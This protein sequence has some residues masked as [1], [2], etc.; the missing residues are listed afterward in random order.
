LLCQATARRYQA[1]TGIFQ[2]PSLPVKQR[3]GECLEPAGKDG[4]NNA[5]RD[6]YE[7]DDIHYSMNI[8]FFSISQNYSIFLLLFL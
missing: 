3:L 4:S 7:P 6:K 5:D 8:V 1:E 2:Q